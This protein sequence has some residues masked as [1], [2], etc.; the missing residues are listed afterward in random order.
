MAYKDPIKKKA[1]NDRYNAEHRAQKR[2]YDIR[3][4]AEHPA[5]VKASK[6]RYSMNN[7]EKG[8]ASRSRY[9]AKYPGKARAKR[10]GCIGAHTQDDIFSLWEKQ[11]HKCAVANCPHEIAEQG[12][13][14]YHVDH[15]Q[16]LA[17]GGSNDPENLQLLCRE[18]N[19]GKS[20][21]DPYIWAQKHGLLFPL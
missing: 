15:I 21:K 12:K 5:Q 18:H 16:P 1:Y 3:Y 4:S 17:R 10:R 7:K 2:A 13:H 11:A 14:K 19:W 9:R 6:A 20:A 8:K